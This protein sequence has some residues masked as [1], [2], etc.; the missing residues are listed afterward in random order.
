MQINA[1]LAVHFWNETGPDRISTK[2][3]SAP[4]ILIIL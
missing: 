2:E 4:M 3:W 1:D